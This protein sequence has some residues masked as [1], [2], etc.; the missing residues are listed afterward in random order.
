MIYSYNS[1]I[2]ISIKDNIPREG[3]PAV[4]ERVKKLYRL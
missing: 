3:V 2:L 4:E 1:K